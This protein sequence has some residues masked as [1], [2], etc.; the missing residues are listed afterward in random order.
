MSL[1]LLQSAASALGT[2]ID[3]RVAKEGAGC[4]DMGVLRA[5]IGRLTHGTA[6]PDL[7][8]AEAA[9]AEQGLAAMLERLLAGKIEARIT[10]SAPLWRAMADFWF[11]RR[12]YRHCLDCYVKAY[13]CLSQLPQVAYAPP[14]FSDAAEAAL[15]LVSMYENL[16]DRTQVVRSAPGAAAGG[17]GECKA[18]A[19]EQPV[20]ADWRRQSQLLLRGLIGKA[21]ESFDGTPAFLRLADALAALRQS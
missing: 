15:D 6:F 17:E 11:W 10:S 5:I 19:V 7:P 16:G 8:A 13:R 3:L 12:D 20:C 2:V 14:V 1:G 18:A 4:V 21:K 9:A